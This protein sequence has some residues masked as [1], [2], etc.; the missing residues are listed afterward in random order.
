MESPP[1]R[2][3]TKR[4]V[5]SAVSIKVSFQRSRTIYTWLEGGGGGYRDYAVA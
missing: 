1:D 2:F 4:S 3:I 5:S